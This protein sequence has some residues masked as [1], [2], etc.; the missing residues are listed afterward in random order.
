MTDNHGIPALRN[1]MLIGLVLLEIKVE[2]VCWYYGH[3]R[4]FN[5]EDL[6]RKHLSCHIIVLIDWDLRAVILLIVRV[7][8]LVLLVKV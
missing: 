3:N 6:A 7:S 4:S 1:H 2:E 8:V 5:T